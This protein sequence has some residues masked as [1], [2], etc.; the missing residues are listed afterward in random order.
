M[1]WLVLLPVFLG[2]VEGRAIA[3]DTENPEPYTTVVKLVDRW[4]L[5]PE[6]IS[7]PS[8]LASAARTLSD[9]LP[10][11]AIAIDHGAVVLSRGD[12]EE[13]GR[14]Y[15]ATTAELPVALARMVSLVEESG[16]PSSRSLSLVALDGMVHSLDR[17]TRVLAD[18]RLDRFNERLTGTLVGIGA[19]FDWS[20]ERLLVADI[21]PHG[22]ADLAGLK[23][24]DEVLRIDGRSTVSMPMSEAS[25]RVCGEA[26]TQVSLTVR[27]GSKDMSVG[28]TRAEVVLP[29]VTSRL[30][31]GGV[32]YVSIDHVSQQTVEN[33]R[34]AMADL[35]RAHGLDTGLV[36]DLRGNTG[37]SMK[38]SAS[39]ADLF[40]EEGLLLR[41]QG[42]DGG[43][44]QNLQAEMLATRDD[45]EPNIPIV[46]V[47]DERTASGSEIMAGA[48]E[49]LDR[50]ALIGTR[51]YGKGTVQKVYPLATDVRLKLTV[52]RY[53]LAND[54]AITESGITPDVV[55]GQ[56]R[57]DDINVL[58]SEPT[59]SS[60]RYL[61]WDES[62]QQTPWNSIVPELQINGERA[63]L[64][65]EIARRALLQTKGT[66]RDA[67]LASL[68]QE[69]SL[70]RSEQLSRLASAYSARSID[71]SEAETSSSAIPIPVDVH[72]ERIDA[73]T[74]RL[75]AVVKNTAP[76][77]LYQVLVQLHC[78]TLHHWD[79]VVIPIGRVA[80]GATSAGSVEITLPPGIEARQD[81]VTVR[82]RADRRPAVLLGEQVLDASSSAL[83]LI[84]VRAALHPE[85][86]KT[87]PHGHPIGRVHIVVQNLSR[88]AID[89]AEVHFGF[90]GTDAIELLD[91]GMRIPSIAARSE[92]STDLSIEVAPRHTATHLPLDLV[93]DTERFGT[94][95]WWPLHLPTDGTEIALQ[96]PQ[97]E[98]RPAHRSAA[99]GPMTLPMNITD[100]GDVSYVVVTVNGE[101]V[102]FSEPIPSPSGRLQLSP[103]FELLPGENLVVIKAEDD[104]GLRTVRTIPIR[105]DSSIEMVDAAP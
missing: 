11:L 66:H 88:T 2:G 63:D 52:A 17:H 80:K 1:Q 47:V 36:I 96:A 28:L 81:T 48:L 19:A 4:F 49:E 70:A 72:S 67:I 75:S 74:W 55:V 58:P 29:N 57:I 3:A 105:G 54:R 87:G 40:L 53:I 77:D 10:W 104:Q 73:D 46:V 21:L 25:R 22:P 86:G 92:A 100:D 15:A 78:P 85:P 16:Q 26:G 60:V 39:A 9:E 71:W 56:I 43:H 50:A 42:A 41:T 12:G 89:G 82:L 38:E 5:Y 24:G 93:I 14:V 64:S 8:M 91:H 76:D 33:L 27:R 79:D 62:W 97:I 13:I 69:A 59:H 99:V 65:V 83:P 94:L 35:D 44:V 6:R 90:P 20:G 102:A 101:K 84:R 61:G 37:G 103:A 7:A 68:L 98:A 32:G 30:L 31:P 18:E 51:T 23:L 34:A 95:A 45:T